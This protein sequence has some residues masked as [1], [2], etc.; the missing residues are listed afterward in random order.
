MFDWWSE[1]PGWLRV[2]T[3]LALMVGGVLVAYFVSI[4]AGFVMLGVGTV[5]VLIGGPSDSEKKGYRF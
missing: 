4:R 1:L 3:A 5:L 2:T